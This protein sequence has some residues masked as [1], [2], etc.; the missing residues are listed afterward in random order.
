MTILFVYI[1]T[2]IDGKAQILKFMTQKNCGKMLILWCYEITHLSD[3]EYRWTLN[4]SMINISPEQIIYNV[5]I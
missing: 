4:A 3:G 2:I 1:K 5:C